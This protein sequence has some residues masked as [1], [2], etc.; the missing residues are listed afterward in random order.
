M[1]FNYKTKRYLKEM[2]SVLVETKYK[3]FSVNFDTMEAFI[4]KQDKYKKRNGKFCNVEHHF[5]KWISFNKE[6]VKYGKRDYTSFDS[7]VHGFEVIKGTRIRK[8]L[9]KETKQRL[10]NKYKLSL[11][12]F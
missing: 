8:F 3:I 6:D 4:N 10:I 7:S 11:S 9:D 2:E 1:Q 5:G 12:T